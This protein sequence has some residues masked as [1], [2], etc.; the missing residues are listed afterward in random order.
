RSLLQGRIPTDREPIHLLNQ[1]ARRFRVIV[2]SLRQSFRRT[3]I[4]AI[5]GA[6]D[7]D[8]RPVLARPVRTDSVK[9]FQCQA[10]RIH[11][12]V[13]ACARRLTAVSR[14]TIASGWHE[15]VSC[16]RE[17]RESDLRRWIR[18]FLTQKDLPQ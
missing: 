7:I 15:P 3:E 9:V 11:D 17:T 1:T 4:A 16:I 10:Q 18:Y 13:A 2:Q 5:Q 8:R 14:Q 6:V 12:L